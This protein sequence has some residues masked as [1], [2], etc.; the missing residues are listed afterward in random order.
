M[1]SKA[2]EQLQKLILAGK[3]Y[4]SISAK[5]K[6]GV[7]TIWRY[8][9]RHNLTKKYKHWTSSE[10]RLLKEKYGSSSKIFQKIKK[11]KAA[12]YKKAFKLGINRK[13]RK[14]KYRLNKKFFDTWTLQSSYVMGWLY[15]DGNV[16]KDLRT[17]SLHLN[18]KDLKIVKHIKKALKSAHPI[19]LRGKYMEFRVHSKDIVKILCS[20]GCIPNKT[21]KIRFP[22][23]LSK[24]YINHFVRGYFDGDGSIHF[25]KPNTIKIRIVGYYKFIKEL[26]EQIKNCARVKATKIKK[27]Q[28]CWAIEIYGDNARSFCKWI[29]KGAGK[30][31]LERKYRRYAIHLKKR[32][33]MWGS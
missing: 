20:K 28:G 3:T 1:Q 15:S 21:K 13:F 6:I 4:A 25:N 11:T 30:L 7:S 26:K 5:L 16:T 14:R 8:K 31:Y 27:Q 10:T 24:K 17:F 29:Y 18:K 32:R 2:D 23:G 33:E 19:V 9:H 12:I 22:K